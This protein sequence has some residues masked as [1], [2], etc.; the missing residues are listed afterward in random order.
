MYYIC[1]YVVKRTDT[2]FLPGYYQSANDLMVTQALRPM[3]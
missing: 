2:M 1:M 3:K